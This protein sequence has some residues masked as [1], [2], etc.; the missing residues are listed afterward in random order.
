[1]KLFWQQDSTP[2]CSLGLGDYFREPKV[3]SVWS[4]NGMGVIHVPE[5][6]Q[7]TPL[8]LSWA[9]QDVH[10][11]QQ[12]WNR[13]IC[14]LGKILPGSTSMGPGHFLWQQTPLSEQIPYPA[15]TS[16]VSHSGVQS[17]PV[18][19]VAGLLHGRQITEI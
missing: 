16:M 6:R 18:G 12:M 19:S 5:Y 1:M 3:K 13:Y 9:I 11:R 8:P 4:R 15:D 14:A 17:Q 2:S 7:L 10:A